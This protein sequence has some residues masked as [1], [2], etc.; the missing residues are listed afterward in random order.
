[1]SY[2]GSQFQPRALK[3]LLASKYA[4]DIGTQGPDTS[5]GVGFVTYLAKQELEQLLSGVKRNSS[6]IRAQAY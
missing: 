3:K 4:I 2:D 5:T 6:G 1:M